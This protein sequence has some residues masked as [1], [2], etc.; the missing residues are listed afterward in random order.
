MLTS[1]RKQPGV[2]KTVTI[3]RFS[4]KFSRK[5]KCCDV[6]DNGNLQ[7]IAKHRKFSLILTIFKGIS[8]FHKNG[9]KPFSLDADL[10][11]EAARRP[12]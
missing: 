5:R 12:A 4:R 6:R 7:K 10:E 9:K 1:S 11:Q 8:Y 3:G 2:E